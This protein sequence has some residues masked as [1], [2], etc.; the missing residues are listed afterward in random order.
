MSCGSIKVERREF[1]DTL[2]PAETKFN[3]RYGTIFKAVRDTQVKRQGAFTR[4][5]CRITFGLYPFGKHVY[6]P[7]YRED[8]LRSRSKP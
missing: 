6:V 7:A 1:D 5:M 4:F 3:D 2:I 8:R